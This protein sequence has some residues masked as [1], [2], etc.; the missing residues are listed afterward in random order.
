MARLNAYLLA[1]GWSEDSS[2]RYPLVYTA[3]VITAVD[4]SAIHLVLYPNSA[5]NW[6][7]SVVTALNLVAA[8]EDR[9]M[10]A[11]LAEWLEPP[12]A[13]ALRDF[14]QILET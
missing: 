5:F 14:I 3:P 13:Q 12:A 6:T 2:G 4:G 10:I 1:H 11:V 7:R 8:I 9:P